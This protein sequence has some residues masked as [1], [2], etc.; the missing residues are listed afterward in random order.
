QITQ[1]TGG[2]LFLHDGVTPVANS[3]FLT[4]REGMAGLRF[5]PAPDSTAPGSFHVQAS[6]SPDTAGLG[7]HII[8]ATIGVMPLPTPQLLA[9][10]GLL[11]TIATTATIAPATLKVTENGAVAGQL[12]YTITVAPTQGVLVDNG[13][14]L[15]AGD[16]FSESDVE[17]GRLAYVAN[18]VTA[19]D[20]F[21]FIVTDANG[22]SLPPAVFSI[23]TTSAPAPHVPPVP[24]VPQ[25]M[26]LPGTT[27]TSSSTAPVSAP[28]IEIGSQS[29]GGTN[30][31]AGAT[32][33]DAS[34]D[35]SSSTGRG[36]D[37]TTARP[38]PHAPAASPVAPAVDQLIPHTAPAR[39][40]D[41]TQQK[42]ADA[43]RSGE[44]DASSNDPS[45][46]QKLST[47]LLNSLAVAKGSNA[48]TLATGNHV[49]KAPAKP[50]GALRADGALWHEL[51]AMQQQMA[52]EHKVHLVAGTASLVSIGMSVAYFMWA[53]RAGSVLS[54]LLSSMPAWKLVDPLPILDQMEGR[55]ARRKRDGSDDEDD[56]SLES[57]VDGVSTVA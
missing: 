4:T 15:A 29:D 52:S 13:R 1:I 43:P 57:M 56:E 39:S 31:A 26:P 51:D 42:A 25:F 14:Q 28:P 19:T 34:G 55:T 36:S 32:P 20:S 18:S 49:I 24:H 30:S 40:S 16:S 37:S 6:L 21:T 5:T 47:G 41:L 33:S 11:T 17:R 2:T 44:S 53:V 50:T 35:S 22:T 54:S 45:E 3:D 8:T 9:N 10:T 38:A 7:G 12:F 23:Q 46:N 27:S 48:S